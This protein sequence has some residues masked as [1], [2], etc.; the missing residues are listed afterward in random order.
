MSDRPSDEEGP[1]IPESSLAGLEKVKA[2]LVTCCTNE[3][4]PTLIEVQNLVSELEDVADQ[5]G[6][7]QASS[8]SG[9][10]NGEWLV[11]NGRITWYAGAVHI[12][13]NTVLYYSILNWVNRPRC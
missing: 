5:I 9:L 3:K 10:M 4:K 12:L 13:S 1:R 2:A 8:I 6:A 7:G 11:P